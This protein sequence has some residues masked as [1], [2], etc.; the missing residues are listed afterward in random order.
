MNRALKLPDPQRREEAMDRALQHLDE[1]IEKFP[2]YAVA[3]FN[4]AELRRFR[5]QAEAAIEDLEKAIELDP[6]YDLA[7]NRLQAIRALMQK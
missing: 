3:W 2:N 5:G 7:K 1:T 6:D 4:R